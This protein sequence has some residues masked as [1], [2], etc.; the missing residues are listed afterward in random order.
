VDGFFTSIFAFCV[1]PD[2][3]A[4]AHATAVHVFPKKALYGPPPSDSA[5]ADFKIWRATYLSSQSWYYSL[6]PQDQVLLFDKQPLP[7]YVVG[8]EFGAAI[9]P[10]LPQTAQDAADP[11]LVMG[12]V[13]QSP[14]ARGCVQLSD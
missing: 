10:A 2:G 13:S 5:V 7:G 1:Q 11:V 9:M 8:N 12:K 6:P 4:A 14:G 3:T